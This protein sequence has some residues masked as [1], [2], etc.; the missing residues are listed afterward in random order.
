M[1]VPL[2]QTFGCWAPQVWPVA[3][4][5][6]LSIP[7]HVSVAMPQSNPCDAHVWG[8]HEGFPQTFCFPPPAQDSGAVQLPQS[9]RLPQP[10]GA[11]PQSKPRSLQL[12]YAEHDASPVDAS[13]VIKLPEELPESLPPLP[14]PLPLPPLPLPLPSL[15]VASPA[16]PSEP[17]PPPPWSLL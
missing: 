9:W 17:E 15:E 14:L 11:M 4:V 10:S 16:P 13:G 2:P 12:L 5:P 3:H 1:Q 6:Q 8:V 7:P